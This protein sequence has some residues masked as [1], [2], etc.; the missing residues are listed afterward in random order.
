[1]KMFPCESKF[2][3]YLESQNKSWI[4]Q[5]ERF[6]LKDTT[7][8]ADFYCPEDD[9]YYEVVGTRQ[10]ISS[11][12]SKIQEFIKT[13]PNIKF[14]IVRPDG[15]NYYRDKKQVMKKKFE[16]QSAFQTFTCRGCIH[17]CKKTRYEQIIYCPQK[18]L[19]IN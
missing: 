6:K 13:Y 12:K 5:P 7:Y 16:L 11:L 14:K 1:M 2:A 9:T 10:A 17:K 15:K 19:R 4:F 3:N 8:R 18:E